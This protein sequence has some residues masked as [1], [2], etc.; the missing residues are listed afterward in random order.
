MPYLFLLLFILFAQF[1]ANAQ[2]RTPLRRPISPNQPTWFVH[3][4]TWNFADPQ[5]II[6]LIPADIRPYVIFNISM[7]QGQD[8][9]GWGQVDSGYETA[10]SWL[11]TCAQNRVWT[12]IQPASGGYSHF[13]DYD[14]S[15][16]EEFFRNYPNFLGINYCEQF[17][18]FNDSAAT[19]PSPPW[20]HRVAHWAR[21]LPLSAKY[22]GYLT[23]SWCGNLYGPPINPIGMLKRNPDF[24]RACEQ[25]TE[26]FILCEKYTQ[27]AYQSD[28]ESLCLGAYLSGYSGNYGIRYDSTGWT[29]STKTPANFTMA[30]AGAP[31]LE[32]AML[33]GQTVIDG[34]ELIWAQ[35][36]YE[37][38][39]VTGA[40]GYRSRQWFRYPQF[41]NMSIDLFR[42]ILDGTVRIPT[43]QELIDRTKV[44]VI[45]DLNTGSS[46]DIYSTPTTLFEGL[47]RMDGDG[48]LKDNMTFFKKTGRYP[49]LPT[50]YNLADA[51]ARSFPIQVSKSGYSSRWP[52]LAAKQAELNSL[53]PEEYTGDLFAGRHE[54]GWVVYNPYKTTNVAGPDANGS[55]P[56]KY[57][58][59][60]RMELT[61][62][63][64]ASG[65]I[66][67]T[68]SR[69]SF[70]LNN[71]DN[72][73]GL[74]MRTQTIK[75][76][77]STVEP[78]W[79]YTDRANHEASTLS[80][81]WTDGVFTLTVTHNG[82]L[83]ISVNCA[84]MA[85][86]RLVHHTPATL[87]VP[88]QPMTYKGPLQFEGELF[89]H[90]NISGNVANGDFT[91]PPP[92]TGYTGQGYLKFGT[93]STA[94]VRDTVTVL[95]NGTYRLETRYSSVGGGVGTIDLYVNGSKLADLS[96]TDTG[97]Y[98][99]WAVDARN[100]TL[101][102]GA[103]IIE[104]RAGATA[105]YSIYFD[106]FMV[107]PTAYGD[108]FVI[109]ENQSGFATVDGAVS[110]GNVGYTGT[111]FADT[112][113]VA[114]AGIDWVLDFDSSTVKSFIF[115]YASVV[116]GT[117]NLLVGGSTVVSNI[118]F[119][120]TGALSSWD[121]VTVYAYIPAGVKDVRLE[122]LSS[123]GLPNV[124]SLEITG[125]SVWVAGKP[126]FLPVGLS[127]TAVSTSQIDL[128]WT[129]A[130]G[131][132]GYVVRRSSTSGGPYTTLATGVSG[133]GYSDTGRSELATYYY[134]VSAINANGTSADSAE[135]SATTQSAVPPLAPTGLAA[136]TLSL[137]RINLT[138]N[139]VQ[140]AD[141]YIVK[142]SR[143]SGGPY[144]TVATGV[145]GSVLTDTNLFAGTT[146]YYVISA[147]NQMG[148]GPDSMPSSTAT[149]STASF[150]PIA[151]TMVNDGNAAN[152]IHGSD[153]E[154]KTKND[155]LTD[156]GYNRSTF[157]KFDVSALVNAQTVTLKLTPYQVDG[158]PTL[159]Y[160][161]V[162]DDSWIET[163]SGGMTWNN[164]PA[165]SGSLIASLSG[166][167]V[168]QQKSIDVTM[169]AKSEAAGDG[170]LSLKVSEPNA[171]AILVGFYPKEVLV[172]NLRPA[173]QCTVVPDYTLPTSPADLA[174]M[175]VT[176]SRIDLS[177]VASS[178]ASSYNISRAVTSGGPHEVIATNVTGTVFSD[179]GCSQE[180]AYFYV[181]NAVN[182]AGESV[183]SSE[184]WATTYTSDPPAPPESP[185][186]LLG[187]A[188][189]F[190]QINLSW[191]V[192]PGAVSYQVKR[193]LSS[194]GPFIPV[195]SVV[196]GSTYNDSFL[197]AGTSYHYVV[198]AINENGES[199][200]SNE[201]SMNTLATQ[202]LEA[203]AD[204]Y[205][206]DGGSANTNFGTSTNLV[207]KNG[208]T[209]GSGFNRNSYLRFNVGGLDQ[210]E[211]VALKLVPYQVDGS[212]TFAY[213]LVSD[214]TWSETAMTWNNQPAGSGTIA[215]SVGAY[216]VGVPVSVDV[217]DLVKAEA[218]G[219]G[220]LSL[221]ISD[222][223]SSNMFVG[224]SSRESILNSLRPKLEYAVPSVTVHEAESATLS[225]PVVAT[226]YTD[227]KGTGYAD[228]AGAAGDFIEW[229][230]NVLSSGTYLLEFRYA[231]GAT[232]DRPLEL[233]VNG[234]VADDSLSFPP[235]GG[236][237]TWTTVRIPMVLNTG[238]NILRL[239][240]IGSSGANID[241]LQ[242]SGSSSGV[243]P[244]A[245][246][247]L[248]ATVTSSS[249]IDLAWA[250]SANAVSYSV[251]RS[252]TSGGPLVTIAT[253]VTGTSYRNSGLSSGHAY[254]Y[255]V[256]AVSPAGES[257]NSNLA[258]A[259]TNL[260]VT[261]TPGELQVSLAWT[262]TA[263]ATNYTVSRST[264]DGAHQVVIA[265]TSS[266][267]YIDTSTDYG[268]IYHYVITA[269]GGSA[270]G[271]STMPVSATPLRG[272]AIVVLGNLAVT[273]AGN[274]QPVTA[275]T[276]PAGLAVDITYGGGSIPP[277]APGTYEISAVIDDANY[278]GSASGLFVISLRSF[279][280][281]QTD[282]FTLQQILDGDTGP[283]ADPDGDGLKNLA[284]YALGTDPLAFTAQ[285]TVSRTA[286]ELSIIFQRPAHIGDVTYFAETSDS[287]QRWEA[288]VLEVLNPGNDPEIVKAAKA[289]ISPFPEREF[290]RL[291]FVR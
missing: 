268:I 248:A 266:P 29:D 75:I 94:S 269:Q 219:D 116:G 119:P 59:C 90:K 18:G 150:E 170:L 280:A 286:T 19:N 57:N 178:G 203:V 231:L 4:D 217:T 47:Y 65:V 51:P 251:K 92:V 125:G 185:T 135:I 133:T 263:E 8:A 183:A 212:A 152:Y 182:G 72:A 15:V 132:D 156:T 83:D 194:G 216:R 247:G 235:T 128:T 114:G 1:V 103:N 9:D 243:I 22:G 31:H 282:Q 81:N 86:D 267:F 239:T 66:K 84:G 112:Y 202:S 36:F 174:A 220:I 137:D 240:A 109:Q 168:N 146:Y 261:A 13:S 143:F 179:L 225:G 208:G 50:V 253:G 154:L 197:F 176:S 63:Q 21:L 12:I 70:Y 252:S 192:S 7:S 258:S 97:S 111:G 209:F 16:Y 234:V 222:L 37:G 270:D 102:A 39:L 184:A 172:S 155:G 275:T 228:Y 122:A 80:S 180:T 55:I 79:S 2:S 259:V 205:V 215:A 188:A 229:K 281:W 117:A 210:A 274:P 26:N 120:S 77:G 250:A 173:L 11:R 260:N 162:T 256:S 189:S 249:E 34:P 221:K 62:S 101:N 262:P 288:L 195:A 161:L 127:G 276:M 68:A 25:Y 52:T 157:L 100:I 207:V 264:S 148:A 78:T 6:D 151:D 198:T 105:P 271:V 226:Q 108:G 224:F 10:K 141:T 64:Y 140:G 191:T 233:K 28:M 87:I 144:T 54:N 20:Q 74:G 278:Q 121:Y 284:E 76:Y 214:D 134:V 41:D 115:R 130:P 255:Q 244:T 123:S 175:A 254:I 237:T 285:P 27:G 42:K 49:T 67:E 93:S 165:G 53:F 181:V 139:S 283:D 145:S 46:D 171:T 85:T 118:P 138:W 88:D 124:D 273:Y 213:E 58:T 160:E 204:T 91:S 104:Y 106:N 17:W 246:T 23:V 257:L 272:A 107:V 166:Y 230:V 164:Q 126:P 186:G 82:P 245:P 201:I 190:Q 147:V 218:L 89:D 238:N 95:K 223:G 149:P 193:S 61:L 211:N 32:H 35:D 153:L 43:R 242:V 14:L 56:F 277:T 187:V 167:T 227:Y 142:R 163:G 110:S 169:I 206:R 159:N 45:N 287:M 44:V 136:L 200:D 99:N 279:T 30:T 33:T 69:V 158:N 48:N 38:S 5:K 98:S 289:S 265:T 290:I 177:W 199:A 236:W 71:H 291:R 60:D 196:N 113:D 3:I 131:A 24:A 96:F 40:D 241:N 73:L 232:V 129:I